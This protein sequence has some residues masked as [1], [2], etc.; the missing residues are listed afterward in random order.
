MEERTEALSIQAQKEIETY[1]E[2]IKDIETFSD[3]LAISVSPFIGQVETSFKSVDKMVG[4]KADEGLTMIGDNTGDVSTGHSGRAFYKTKVVDDAKFIKLFQSNLKALFALSGGAV[5]VFG[6][7]MYQ[8]QGSG[9]KDT[10]MIYF[11]KQECME[12]CD[13]K[14]HNQVY[15]GLVELIKKEFIALST[16]RHHF[17]VNPLYAFNGNRVV[18]VQEFKRKDGLT[19]AG[20]MRRIQEYRKGEDIDHEEV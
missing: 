1:L 6:Y 10:D 8:M 14:V 12:F 5:K 16:R 11:D 15:N 9:G 3:T 19:R 7:F 13:Y 18:I 2:N 4:Y 20:E 17:Y